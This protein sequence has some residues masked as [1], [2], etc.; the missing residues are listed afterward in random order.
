MVHDHRCMWPKI[1]NLDRLNN[2][3]LSKYA[4]N[5]NYNRSSLERRLLR[6]LEKK[7]IKIIGW[8]HACI[9]FVLNMHQVSMLLNCRSNNVCWWC[10]C[11]VRCTGYLTLS[12]HW[13]QIVRLNTLFYQNSSSSDSWRS[14]KLVWLFGLLWCQ[15]PGFVP[16]PHMCH[17]IWSH[18]L[19][20]KIYAFQAVA[21]DLIPNYC[22]QSLYY[23]STKRLYKTNA[24]FQ[25][26]F[27]YFNLENQNFTT[28]YL[29][30]QS[31]STV[32]NEFSH[33]MPLSTE[34]S[35]RFV[36]L[37]LN[38]IYKINKL[39]INVPQYKD[40][41]H[42]RILTKWLNLRMNNCR[43]R[44]FSLIVFFI[45][46]LFFFLSICLNR[47]TFKQV[48][49]K[50]T[51]LLKQSLRVLLLYTFLTVNLDIFII[52]VVQISDI[53]FLAPAFESSF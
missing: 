2:L 32:S 14:I 20:Q 51:N 5:E 18:Y 6:D 45:R 10:R 11:R 31:L 43:L 19:S 15:S 24:H 47:H 48:S 25:L 22:L 7:I 34:I 40:V 13:P 23:Q 12:V 46:R 35:W 33:S 29:P 39:M 21:N 1:G 17:E 44:L 27:W 41:L 42:E 36:A 53:I 26:N 8:S 37:S 3:L 16:I 49:K 30:S 38:I 9:C 28:N 52:F 4:N 50:N